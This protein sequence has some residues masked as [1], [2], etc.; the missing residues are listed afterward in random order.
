V[1]G[2]RWCS[3]KYLTYK[4][5]GRHQRGWAACRPP[6]YLKYMGMGVTARRPAFLLLNSKYMTYNGTEFYIKEVRLW[7]PF[8]RVPD[9]HVFLNA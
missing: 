2:P 1:A 4:G 8:R 7:L 6:K 9:A 3:P 5:V